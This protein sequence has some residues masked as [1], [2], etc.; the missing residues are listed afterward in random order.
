MLQSFRTKTFLSQTDVFFAKTASERWGKEGESELQHRGERA[1]RPGEPSANLVDK[2]AGTT[3][4]EPATSCVTG[5][6]SNQLNYV[7][8]KCSAECLVASG[9]KKLRVTSHEA[10]ATAFLVGGARLERATF[11]L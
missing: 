10:L 6:R 8:W 3:G 2:L 9:Q 4:L 5:M 11:C 1:R 7:P